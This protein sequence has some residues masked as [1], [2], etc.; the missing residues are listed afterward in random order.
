MKHLF[1]LLCA[2]VLSLS[3]AACGGV[4]Q[5]DYD[6]VCAQRDELKA[7]LDR[8]QEERQP[9]RTVVGGTFSAT[10]RAVIP[11]YGLDFTT[12]RAAVLTLFQSPPFI[13]PVGELASELTVG[14]TYVFT[15][16]APDQVE[17]DPD[18]YQAGPPPVEESVACYHMRAVA[19]RPAG[20][21][22][23]GM[24]PDSLTFD[25]RPAPA[26]DGVGNAG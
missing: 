9:V 1:V 7:Q 22:E 3:L 16:E 24:V 13:L 20:E 8:L 21:G 12:P 26:P 14:E 18:R 2:L 6:A 19:V 5:S 11:D 25:Y 10:V 23:R 15:I 4:P 17:V